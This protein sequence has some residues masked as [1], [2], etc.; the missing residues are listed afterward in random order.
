MQVRWVGSWGWEG[1]A[2]CWAA[3]VSGRV[4]SCP[5]CDFIVALNL[6]NKISLTYLYQITTKVI[7]SLLYCRLSS[8]PLNCGGWVVEY[9]GEMVIISLFLDLN[10]IF[11]MYLPE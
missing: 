10:L 4:G 8:Y 2:G 11:K 1:T 7:W 5:G 9:G 6:I 3:F